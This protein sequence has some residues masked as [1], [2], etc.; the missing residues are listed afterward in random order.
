MAYKFEGVVSSSKAKAIPT[1][2]K[3]L[4]DEPSRKLARSYTVKVVWLPNK[5]PNLSLQTDSFRVA[6]Y[7]NNPI[8]DEL[9]KHCQE[10]LISDGHILQIHPDPDG[11]FTISV[12]ESE[13]CTWESLGEKGLKATDFKSRRTKK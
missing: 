7:E 9:V 3:W 10:D 12:N 13:M 2:S 5:Y 1:L 8:F 11:N 6:I 4:K